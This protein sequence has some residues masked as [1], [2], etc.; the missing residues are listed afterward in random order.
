MSIS[1]SSMAAFCLPATIA[2]FFFLF[3]PVPGVETE[4]KW[5]LKPKVFAVWPITE[6]KIFFQL[7]LQLIFVVGLE[8]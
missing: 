2:R 1:I 8:V 5:P 6:K 3:Y 4:T 7:L